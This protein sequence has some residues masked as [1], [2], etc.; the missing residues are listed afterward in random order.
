MSRLI[1][2]LDIPAIEVDDF[3]EELQARIRHGRLIDYSIDIWR[4]T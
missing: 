2:E 1:I 4:E 3:L